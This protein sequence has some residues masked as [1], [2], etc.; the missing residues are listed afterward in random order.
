MRV[1]SPHHRLRSI[2]IIDPDLASQEWLKQELLPTGRP[3]RG[4]LDVEAAQA[5]SD[6]HDV[7]AILVSIDADA[8]KGDDV[9]QPVRTAAC[10]V[11]GA[12]APQPPGVFALARR[13][14]AP[15]AM[16]AA[17]HRGASL[18]ITVDQML[19]LRELVEAQLRA[20]EAWYPMADSGF[21]MAAEGAESDSAPQLAAQSTAMKS[22]TLTPRSKTA[23]LPVHEH[24]WIPGRKDF[25]ITEADP[26]DLKLYESKAVLRAIAAADGNRTLAAQLLGIGKSTLYRRLSEWRSSL[27]Q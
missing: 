1:P 23:D 2:V 8:A 25:E 17:L 6:L 3:V 11:R 19:V 16:Q 13:A 5:H 20:R 22:V 10:W 18:I 4:F 9:A 24:G 14:L 21:M 12:A 27:A 15:S 26:I 7:A